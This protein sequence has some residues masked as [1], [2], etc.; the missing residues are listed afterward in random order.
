MSPSAST[1]TCPPDFA[2]LGAAVGAWNCDGIAEVSLLLLLLLL[3]L[4]P[5]PQDESTPASTIRTGTGKSS[6]SRLNRIF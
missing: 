2:S 6:L 1:V 4:L 3:V 5:P